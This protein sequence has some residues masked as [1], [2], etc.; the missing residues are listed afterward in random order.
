MLYRSP[1]YLL[2]QPALQPLLLASS[3]G[4]TELERW[5]LD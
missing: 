5:A 3:D 4:Y 1:C 2:Y